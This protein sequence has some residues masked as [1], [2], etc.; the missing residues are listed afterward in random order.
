MGA[1]GA[2]AAVLATE[3]FITLAMLWYLRRIG[4]HLLS[5]KP[6]YATADRNLPAS[7]ARVKR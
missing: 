2:G 6:A 4:I 5:Q 3:A 1:P 7:D